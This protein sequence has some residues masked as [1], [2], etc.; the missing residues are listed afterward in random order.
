MHVNDVTRNR[1]GKKLS[2]YRKEIEKNRLV[3]ACGDCCKFCSTKGDDKGGK[4][5]GRRN[6]HR[7]HELRHSYNEGESP[8]GNSSPLN[9][10]SFPPSLYRVHVDE[11]GLGISFPSRA[12]AEGWAG[13]S[14]RQ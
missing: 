5:N 7:T 13:M 4:F 2:A 12:T 11:G 9:L 3:G 8:Y 14:K 6:S 1:T 10:N